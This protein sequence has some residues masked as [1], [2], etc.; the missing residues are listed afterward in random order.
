LW[1]QGKSISEQDLKE[2]MFSQQSNEADVLSHDLSEAL[3]LQGVLDKVE[4]HYTRLAWDKTAG[5]KKKAAE[6]LG[7]SSYQNYSNRL[8]K[9]GI[10]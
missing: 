3:D 10:K 6:L 9:Y 2:A 8:E 5:K 7:L 4:E 1:S